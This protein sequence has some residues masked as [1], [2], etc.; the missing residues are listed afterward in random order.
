MLRFKHFLM[1][2]AKIDDYKAQETNISTE[3]DQHGEHKSASDIIDHFHKHSPGGNIQHTRWMI[4]RYKRGEMKQEDAPDMHDTLKHF[5]KY[6]PQLP[7]KKIEQYKSVSELKTALHPHQEKDEKEKSINQDKIKKGSAV[8]HNS[9]NVTAYHVHTTEASQELGKKGNGEKLGWCTSHPDPKKNMF[10]HYNEK[11]GNN[12]HILHMHKEQF[13]YRR[14]GGVGV[15]GQFQDENNEKIVGGDFHNLLKRNPKLE[16]IPAITNSQHYKI[17]KASN[18]D[19]TKEELHKSIKDK[20]EAVRHAVASNPNATKEHLDKLVNDE[21]DLVRSTVARNTNATKEHLHKLVNDK[22]DAVREAMALHYP[23]KEHLDKLI[24]DKNKRVRQAV[25]NNPNATKEH[26]NKLV[27]DE[28]SAVRNTVAANPNATKEHLDKLV[29]DEDSHVRHTV[30]KFSPHKEHLDKLINDKSF[31]VKHAVASNPNAPKEHLDKLMNNNFDKIAV[32][33]SSP[34]KDHLDKLVN[35]TDK[36][37]RS[38]VARNPHASKEHL[39]KL[40]KDSNKAVRD[41]A[42]TH[43]NYK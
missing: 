11:S 20:D 6:K 16:E 1:L 5:E 35:D 29:N 10:Q 18:P 42:K 12:F 30:A 7:K 2:E 8:V 38:A 23:Y 26:L 39:G 25:G 15:E 13:P 34:H 17:Q 37:I 43:P 36:D 9:P 24:N 40:A 32:A 31:I 14:I 41:E 27:N 22:S 28:S 19:A 33:A 3:H 4:D 21:D